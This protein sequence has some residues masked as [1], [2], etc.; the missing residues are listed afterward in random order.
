MIVLALDSSVGKAFE[1]KQG[2]SLSRHL[3]CPSTARLGSHLNRDTRRGDLRNGTKIQELQ[4]TTKKS[5]VVSGIFL[6]FCLVELRNSVKAMSVSVSLIC[7]VTLCLTTASSGLDLTR[8]RDSLPHNPQVQDLPTDWIECLDEAKICRFLV[9]SEAGFCSLPDHQAYVRSACRK[10]C[11]YCHS[12]TNSTL[13]PELNTNLACLAS[14]IWHRFSPDRKWAKHGYIRG[15]YFVS[16]CTDMLRYYDHQW[17]KH[18]YIRG[19]YFVSVCTDM[20]KYHDHQWAKHGYIR[21]MYFVSKLLVIV[22]ILCSD[23]GMVRLT[24]RISRVFTVSVYSGSKLAGH[25][26]VL[27]PF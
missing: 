27:P 20:L 1:D 15:M 12:T 3:T 11:G 13:D 7:V 21:G 17:A 6:L 9:S 4:A 2:W 5:S 25:A 16:V 19:M 14:G 22:S 8:S 24:H 18:G 26:Q 10:T 23:H